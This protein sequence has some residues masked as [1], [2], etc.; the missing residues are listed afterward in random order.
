MQWGTKSAVPGR[1]PILDGCLPRIPPRSVWANGT[2]T[3]SGF[4]RLWFTHR[5]LGKADF[6]NCAGQIQLRLYANSLPSPC[7]S[8]SSF[9]GRLRSV[10]IGWRDAGCGCVAGVVT[11]ASRSSSDSSHSICDWKTRPK[12]RDAA[13]ATSSMVKDFLQLSLHRSHRLTGKA[14]RDNQVK[15]SRSVETF[16]AKPCVVTPR[17]MCTPMAAILASGLLRSA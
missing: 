17:E 2:S 3:P 7:S 6:S 9:G 5:C 13:V 11:C 15:Y 12:L 16:S 8:R 4:C 14:A 1:T 10:L